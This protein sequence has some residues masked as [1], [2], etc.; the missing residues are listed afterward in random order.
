MIF[1]HTCIGRGLGANRPDGWG[2]L[3]TIFTFSCIGSARSA[4]LNIINRGL[5][6]SI[7]LNIR[8]DDDSGICLVQYRSVCK[9]DT[10]LCSQR[11]RSLTL[12]S[13]TSRTIS[14]SLKFSIICFAAFLICPGNHDIFPAKMKLDLN[15]FIA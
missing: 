12:A 1:T 15:G 11:R 8:L 13:R 2:E 10:L 9:L 4:L 14:T 5:S 3:G 6:H 7:S